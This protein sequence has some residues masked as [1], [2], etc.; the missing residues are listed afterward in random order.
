MKHLEAGS[1]VFESGL[2]SH[3]RI[4]DSN[5][6]ILGI[7]MHDMH[8]FVIGTA[9]FLKQL[10]QVRTLA[11]NSFFYHHTVC[12]SDHSVQPNRLLAWQSKHFVAYTIHYYYYN[13][14]IFT[15]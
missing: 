6:N 1:K 8:I 9:H 7:D 3:D 4:L 15:M 12:P 2:L 14:F 5:S 10:L 13:W 11:D